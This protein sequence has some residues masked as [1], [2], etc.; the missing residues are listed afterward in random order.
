[1]SI[2]ACALLALLTVLVRYSHA[3]L[4]KKFQL[5]IWPHTLIYAAF[6][7]CLGRRTLY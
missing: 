1:M 2:S 7:F 3:F 4:S 6:Y 5:A